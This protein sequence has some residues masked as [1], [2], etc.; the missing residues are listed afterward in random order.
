MHK[1][2]I[3]FLSSQ[4]RHGA[5]LIRR[6]ATANVNNSLDPVGAVSLSM[7]K[8]GS[9]K[10]MRA[11][12]YCVVAARRRW[13]D[14][15]RSAGPTRDDQKRRLDRPGREGKKCRLS[16]QLSRTA[17][18]ATRRHHPFCPSALRHVTHPGSD[19]SPQ[20]SEADGTAARGSFVCFSAFTL[21]HWL[22]PRSG[23]ATG[24]PKSARFA[25]Q[26][27]CV[28][29]SSESFRAEIN[30]WCVYKGV[31]LAT[32][33][34]R[35]WR[36]GWLF[37]DGAFCSVPPA[38]TTARTE[39]SS[40]DVKEREEASMIE[41][42]R[43]VQNG[44]LVKATSSSCSKIVRPDGGVALSCAGSWLG[45]VSI[46]RSNIDLIILLQRVKS[47]FDGLFD[48]D[49]IQCMWTY[50][51]RNGRRIKSWVYRFSFVCNQ[52][53]NCKR[54][55][56]RPYLVA[57]LIPSHSTLRAAALSVINGAPLII[58]QINIPR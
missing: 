42:Y 10:L 30:R 52:P 40:T 13:D 54:I 7:T 9:N 55:A 39:L 38:V 53:T 24:R 27:S 51:F 33:T 37:L 6:T 58:R 22:E 16:P 45:P 36:M 47:D 11:G 17:A 8:I 3:V 32:G 41:S 20:I 35:I 21:L 29:Q 44:W 43:T 26:K 2:R 12:C 57:P 56:Q 19:A 4:E 46:A 23:S 48:L 14:G 49:D 5:P 28:Y 1:R 25:T 31:H 34:G 18:A 50:P 15:R